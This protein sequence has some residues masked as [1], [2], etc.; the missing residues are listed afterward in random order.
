[1]LLLGTTQV[2]LQLVLVVTSFRIVQ[3]TVSQGTDANDLAVA[4]RLATLYGTLNIV[5]DIVL[6]INNL[7]TDTFLAYRC[8]LIWNSRIAVTILPGLLIMAVFLTTTIIGVRTANSFSD[9]EVT[10]ILAA[11]TNII[12]TGLT[13]G[14]IWWMTREASH[15]ELDGGNIFR[16]RYIRVLRIMYDPKNLGSDPTV[17]MTGQRAVTTGAGPA[18]QPSETRILTAG[19]GSGSLADGVP[20]PGCRRGSP[21]GSLAIFLMAYYCASEACRVPIP[22]AAPFTN[23]TNTNTVT[24]AAWIASITNATYSYNL[25]VSCIATRDYH[26]CHLDAD[27]EHNPSIK[28][29]TSYHRPQDIELAARPKF[30]GLRKAAVKVRP[31]SNPPRM[32][33]QVIYISVLLKPLIKGVSPA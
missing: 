19:S 27:C 32:S 23:Y 10:F 16:R 22:S 14:R 18:V 25:F 29:H 31:A 5:Q 11:I 20:V 12:I 21:P 2:L 24:P 26:K 9:F 17:K 30:T 7:L 3:Q 6:A 13:A 4:K 8:Y 1:M 28:L 33:S 15:L